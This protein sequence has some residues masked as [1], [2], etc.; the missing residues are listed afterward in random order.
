M[1]ARELRELSDQELSLKEREL[2]ET[3]FRF[4]LRRGTNQLDN[5]AALRAARRDI[6]RIRTIRTERAAE[7]NEGE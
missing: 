3:V 2:R 5:P 7:R 4:R 1:E 6:A